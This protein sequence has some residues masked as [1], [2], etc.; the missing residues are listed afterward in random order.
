[1]ARPTVE[2]G[3]RAP[4]GSLSAR[5]R[6]APSL[7]VVAPLNVQVAED[8]AFTELASALG[9]FGNV[10]ADISRD[11][12]DRKHRR[13]A[14]E[15]AALGARDAA[16]GQVD[17]QRR[18]KSESYARAADRVTAISAGTKASFEI[19]QQF[20]EWRRQNP[21]A[22]TTE[23]AAK[24][25]ELIQGFLRPDGE[26]PNP[27]LADGR[28]ASV[29]VG[30]LQELRYRLLDKDRDFV[31]NRKIEVGVASASD[32]FIS[33][34]LQNK[35]AKDSD[36][37]LLHTQLK[38]LGLSGSDINKVIAETAKSASV[39]LGSSQPIKALPDKWQ[40]GTPSVKYTTEY[41]D[42]LKVHADRL[43]EEAEKARIEALADQ[44]IAWVNRVRARASNGIGLTQ[45]DIDEAQALG[46]SEGTII[47]INDT[48]AS[49][50]EYLAEKRERELQKA[51][52][53][54]QIRFNALAG[55]Q[56]ANT[57]QQNGKVLDEVF[58]S[59]ETPRERQQ[60][61]IQQ[62]KRGMLPPTYRRFLSMPPTDTANF[63]T[64]LRN[65][66]QLRSVN[67]SLYATLPDIARAKAEAF[68]ALTKTGAFTPEQALNRVNSIDPK[69]GEDM[70]KRFG[71]EAVSDILDNSVFFGLFGEDHSGNLL[72]RRRAI[73][74]F[75]V[76]ASLPDVDETEATHMAKESFWAN[77]FVRDGQVYSRAVLP[78]EDALDWIK[79]KVAGELKIDVDDVVV[80][81]DPNKPVLWIRERG[82]AAQ[83]SVSAD[84]LRQEWF[85]DANRERRE[86]GSRVRMGKAQMD[87]IKS[88]P[89]WAIPLVP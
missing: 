38:A 82:S 54:A 58:N 61:V 88:Q 42:D 62:A 75:Q 59:L 86:R 65:I 77:H 16:L 81:Q 50:R 74:T 28:A 72:A 39:Q 34:V 14:E 51:E 57:P 1:M 69:K 30:N 40:D 70:A 11:A 44:R 46:V 9:I 24:L 45:K 22:D 60:F 43:D 35:A 5:T 89:G 25:D 33:V 56:W 73:S 21:D 29:V 63:N 71:K 2:T 37:H 26:T 47:G 78:D 10:A 55:N 66:K 31:I 27:L 53:Q 23:A 84:V 68:E 36:W 19:S 18:A 3:N 15:D 7:D 80:A 79:E 4:R 48:A 52:L 17:E 32:Q 20:E 13:Q 67:P 76:F 41:G 12:I 6:A 87:Y 8:N 85:S 64:W 83:H 49:R